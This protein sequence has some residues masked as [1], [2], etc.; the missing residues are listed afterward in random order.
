[1]ATL[2]LLPSCIHRH[3]F[4]WRR[5]PLARE[6]EREDGADWCISH[7]MW[8]ASK[9]NTRSPASCQLRAYLFSFSFTFFFLFRPFFVFLGWRWR[10]FPRVFHSPSCVLVCACVCRLGAVYHDWHT[11]GP[12]RWVSPTVHDLCLGFFFT[13]PKKDFF[14][15]VFLVQKH[16]FPVYQCQWM[17]IPRLILHTYPRWLTRFNNTFLPPLFCSPNVFSALRFDIQTSRFYCQL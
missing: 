8:A 6:I 5:G 17:C 15:G 7:R 2:V 1:M 16:F 3:T 9:S 11:L 4:A 12:T 10:F 13:Q 14:A